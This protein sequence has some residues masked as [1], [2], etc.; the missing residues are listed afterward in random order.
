MCSTCAIFL[1]KPQS[2]GVE[3]FIRHDSA[4][5]L[6]TS[7]SIGQP[8]GLTDPSLAAHSTLPCLASTPGSSELGLDLKG[9]RAWIVWSTTENEIS[10]QG[11]SDSEFPIRDVHNHWDSYA[12]C[13]R[14]FSLLCIVNSI[15]HVQECCVEKYSTTCAYFS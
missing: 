4:Q 7:L 11:M 14:D 9:V 10:L 1:G 6:Q 5:S 8:A 2:F 3:F 13:R 12:H 15:I